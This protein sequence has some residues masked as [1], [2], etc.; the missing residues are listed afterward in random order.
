MSG[1]TTRFK[2]YAQS[3][4]F[5][6]V[7]SEDKENRQS[8]TKSTLDF[9]LT[10]ADDLKFAIQNAPDSDFTAMYITLSKRLKEDQKP[11]PKKRKGKGDDADE[12]LTSKIGHQ[13]K[14]N[15]V[16]PSKKRRKVILD[17]DEEEA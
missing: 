6:G 2:D 10:S 13:H 16:E 5:A 7:V 15:D 11:K 8:F 17:S 14:D 9:A 12:D 4:D 1:A 3:H